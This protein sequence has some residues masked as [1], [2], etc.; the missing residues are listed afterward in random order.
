MEEKPSVFIRVNL[1]FKISET[2][3]SPALPDLTITKREE[4]LNL[5]EKALAA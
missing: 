5:C 1:W 3:R 2:K 4:R